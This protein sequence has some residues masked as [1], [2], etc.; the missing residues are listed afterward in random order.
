LIG[1]GIIQFT[2]S[3]YFIWAHERTQQNSIIPFMKN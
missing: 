3:S 2:W 1:S